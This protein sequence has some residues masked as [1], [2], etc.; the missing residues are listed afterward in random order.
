MKKFCFL[1]IFVL[2]YFISYSQVYKIEKRTEESIEN[3]KVEQN[4]DCLEMDSYD[5]P[6]SLVICTSHN[7]I[8]SSLIVDTVIIVMEFSV[9]FHFTDTTDYI[10][11]GN[12]RKY[13]PNIIP[14][15]PDE[16][17]PKSYFQNKMIEFFN[18]CDFYYILGRENPGNVGGYYS[19]P[20]IFIPQI[21]P[22]ENSI[23]QI[24]SY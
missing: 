10:V 3:I 7:T 20:I 13:A 8:N 12:I 24:N 9:K 4:I 17:L 18:S 11:I 16:E 6:I 23:K 21:P 2:F 1:I 5:Y 19:I 14:L 15:C 22:C